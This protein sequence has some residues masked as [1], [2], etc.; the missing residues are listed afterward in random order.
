[1]REH[2]IAPP[3]IAGAPELQP[4]LEMYYS[5]FWALDS[6][7]SLGFGASGRIPWTAINT[8]CNRHGIIGEQRVDMEHHVDKLDLT[9]LK[10]QSDKAEAKRRAMTGKGGG[11]K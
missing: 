3:K 11:K 8:W 10:F 4:G 2:G 6:C 7:R 5:A 9:L 1:M